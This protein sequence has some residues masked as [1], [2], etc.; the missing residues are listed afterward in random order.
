MTIIAGLDVTEY[1]RD[2]T[3]VYAK[4]SYETYW[5]RIAVASSERDA[6]VI[7][8]ALQDRPEKQ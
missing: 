2:G 5:N 4:K 1:K 8:V 3:S 6:C 7:L